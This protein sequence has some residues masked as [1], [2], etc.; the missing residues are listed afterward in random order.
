[1]SRLLH[2]MVENPAR[3]RPISA[4]LLALFLPDYE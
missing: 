2:S 1:M 4:C 3:I